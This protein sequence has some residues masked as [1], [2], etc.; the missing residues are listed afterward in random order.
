MTFETCDSCD[1]V[2]QNLTRR[3]NWEKALVP[4]SVL[5][6]HV[7]QLS[8]QAGN[9]EHFVHAKHATTLQHQ[10]SGAQKLC[11]HVFWA[12]PNLWAHTFRAHTFYFG[13]LH[14][15]APH[16]HVFSGCARRVGAPLWRKIC[17][18]KNCMHMRAHVLRAKVCVTKMGTGRSGTSVAQKLC[19]RK[20][21]AR[22]V[23]W[24]HNISGRKHFG[25]F[26]FL[27]IRTCFALRQLENRPKS[28]PF[29]KLGRTRF[30][31]AKVV[32]AKFVGPCPPGLRSAG[33]K[34]TAR[35]CG[36]AVLGQ[37]N[38][39]GRQI[40]GGGGSFWYFFFWGG[41]YRLR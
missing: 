8:R 41:S 37:P 23:G 2:R 22:K 27:R 29:Q 4:P 26:T 35:K 36:A 9:C 24:G 6:S 19:A 16:A 40:F 18:R 15:A 34:V 31:F 14:G 5:F 1:F 28:G 10:L 30:C 7:S 11:A 3:F 13:G 20:V 17:P 39:P 25:R 33:Q 12:S 32:V 21:C 38:F